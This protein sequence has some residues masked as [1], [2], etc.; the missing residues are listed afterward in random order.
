VSRRRV[1]WIVFG[2]LLAV[3]VAGFAA[4]VLVLRSD[5]FHEKVRARIVDTIETATGGRAEVRSFQ[6]DWRQLRAE[7]DG[8]TLH[9]N[10]PA[11]RP[12]LLRA[13]SIAVGLKIV[14]ALRRDIDIQSLEVREPHIY[15]IVY[16]DGR[17]NIP[18]PKI[19]S[20]NARTAIETLLNLAVGQFQI[21]NGIFEMEARGKTP[22][23]ANGRNLKAK[24][25]YDP[26]SPLYRGDLSIDPLD[27]RWNGVEPVPL[28]IGIELTLERNRIAIS[29][30]SW[31]TGN[32]R[33]E[34]SGAIEN[35]ASPRADF[36]FQAAASMPEMARIFHVPGLE[37]GTAQLEGSATW[38]GASNYAVLGKLHAASVGFRQD[39]VQIR[40]FRAEGDLRAG[41][42]K[43]DLSGIRLSG[44]TAY[45]ADWFPIQGTVANL[46]LRDQNIGFRGASLALLGGNFQG[47]GSLES[48]REFRVTG[49]IKGF[50]ARRVVAVYNR[51]QMLPW[52]SLIAGPIN[53]EGSLGRSKDIRA[54][55]N[56]TLAPVPGGPAVWGEVNATFDARNG[57]LDLGTSIVNLPSS[58][59]VISGSIGK[60]MRVHLESRDL[61]DF[62]PVL[63][64]SS[65]SLPVK[66]ES[67]SVLFDGT[68]TGNMENP[69]VAGRL[70]LSRFAYDGKLFDS[71][72]AAV[73]A[74]P[75]TV[76]L[77]HATLI[78]GRLR[79]EFQATLGLR[80]WKADETSSIAAT[81]GVHNAALS[82]LAGLVDQTKLPASGT[83]SI[84]G[85]V[86][87]T[88]G[89]P[90]GTGDIEVIKGAFQSEPFDRFEAH[91]SYTGRTLQVFAG[92]VAAGAKHIRFEGAFDHAAESF[93]TGRLRFDLQSDAMPLDQIETI[94][95]SRS[96]VAGTVQFTARGA[97]DLSPAGYR[98]VDLNADFTG[99]G[100]RLTGQP[101]GDAHVTAR[102]QGAS[103]RVSLDSDVADSM[104]K[105]QGEWR[106][107]GD[108]PG[109]AELTFSRLDLTELHAW[110]A[111][112]KSG[113]LDKIG[114]FAE[115]QLQMAGPL[116]KPELLKAKL[117][118]P[119][120]ELAPASQTGTASKNVFT[121]RNSGPI[122]A[123]IA[124]SAVTI[125]NAH[126]VGRSTDVTVAAKVML[127]QKQPLD[128]RVNGQA[129]LALLHDFDSG[130]T[131][132]GRVNLD[133]G[134][135]GTLDAPQVTGRLEVENAALNY[136]DVPN[137]L[138]NAS[139][140]ILFSG[141]RATIQ[142]MAGETGGGKLQFSGFAAYGGGNPAFRVHAD[143]MGVR[144]RYP[145]GVSTVAN[146]SLDITGTA[147]RSLLTG[148]ISILRSG[149]NVQSDF[150]SLLAKSA[151]PVRTPSSQ[152][153]FLDGLNFD[154]T[155]DTAPDVQ[156]E[157]SLA[158]GIVA[159]ASLRLRGTP[160]N[161]AM[162]GRIHISQ[163]QILFFGTKYTIDQGSISFFNAVRIEPVLDIDLETKA[164]GI[165]ITLSVTGP[166]NRLNVTPRSDPPLQFSEIVSLLAT[167]VSP[168]TDP[169]LTAVQ[170]VTPQPFQQSASALLGQVISS[171][172][173]GRLQ[174]FFGISKVRIDPTLPGITNNP[175]AR[176]TLEQQVTPE[177]TFTYITNVS[178][179][180]PQVVSV[181]WAV[182]K[183]FSVLAQREE[184]GLFGLDFF[185]K[186]QFK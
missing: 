104:V 67:G 47:D 16:P 174:R 184:N 94:R 58:R 179:A 135:R 49:A 95:N 7:V 75:E 44:E 13:R 11:D 46:S 85:Q 91:V 167:G 63:G 1:V 93:R 3:V 140:V 115:G 143:A 69:Q 186:K 139:G 148:N 106:L 74:S 117:T 120:F 138:S 166:L 73:R 97:A 33:V 168:S 79:A 71:L 159:D 22:F 156:F 178:N 53:L 101:L 25:L 88:L 14:S 149:F 64:E 147:K 52:D 59:A 32:S 31:T 50:Q 55:A 134:V 173:S 144:V 18:E 34:F 65:A 175:L 37:R 43:L 172:V 130:I 30:A 141:D 122:V 99:R 54:S 182:S 76:Q 5:W 41:A 26:A 21:E 23:D 163:G 24:F 96:G 154:V 80:N 9:G 39:E 151:E 102:S 112:A 48:F 27:V 137:G 170:N 108:Y 181:E 61:G 35:L 114:G 125:Q 4:A 185:Y 72:Q 36:R 121:L 169:N 153:G 56:L 145:E 161:P 180:N 109:S 142:N 127:Q 57:V 66:L 103:L 123:E 84:T 78:R 20:P 51:R 155:I 124:N 132:S 92:E 165:D 107:D 12:P 129:D 6:F 133:A 42:G 119:S 98:L 160:A 15:L 87:G 176:L 150:S 17:T 177:I 82:D 8:F 70:S 118:I 40:N 29:S 45:N 171:P 81:G 28:T 89:D 158:Q 111:P 162:L 164:R 136:A 157:S 100:L 105:G 19:K 110:L 131:S 38:A 77:E 116:L 2:S 152:A 60:Q 10:E 128:L 86:A 183:Q 68:V 90:H 62:L 113:V 83:V 126:L 146:A